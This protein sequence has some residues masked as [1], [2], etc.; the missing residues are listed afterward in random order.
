MEQ[1][2]SEALGKFLADRF[3]VGT[4]PK[5]K[6]EVSTA[7]KPTPHGFVS[8][9][10]QARGFFTE[11]CQ[12]LPFR[13][14]TLARAPSSPTAA[15]STAPLSDPLLL[16]DARGDQCDACGNLLNPTELLNPKCKFSGTQ[17]VIRSTRHI[18][19]DLPQLS[20]QLQDYITTTSQLGGWSSNCVQVTT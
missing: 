18:F 4:C 2:Y 7:I 14:E 16:Q 5:C 1:L 10:G 11:A 12:V 3:V 8:T 9:H 6:Y 15:H 20:P 19:L 17:P 13:V